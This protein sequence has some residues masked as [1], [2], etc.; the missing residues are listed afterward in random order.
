M[1]GNF[2]EAPAGL[3][4]VEREICRTDHKPK[5]AGSGLE[6]QEDAIELSREETFRSRSCKAAAKI[7]KEAI[8][9]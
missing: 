5:E 3:E 6:R 4:S 8:L 1:S 7:A 9:K 2:L